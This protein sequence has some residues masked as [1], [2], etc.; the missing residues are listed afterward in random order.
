MNRHKHDNFKSRALLEQVY[1][2]ELEGCCVL[3]AAIKEHNDQF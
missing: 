2:V 1:L 3:R